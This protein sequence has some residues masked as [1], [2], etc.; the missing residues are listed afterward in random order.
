MNNLAS[1]GGR[2]TNRSGGYCT[3]CL[4]WVIGSSLITAALMIGLYLLANQ[5]VNPV[6][7]LNGVTTTPNSTLSF[8]AAAL[9]VDPPNITGT[10]VRTVPVM[11]VD[12]HVLFVQVGSD[13]NSA[14]E[15][16]VTNETL[17]YK[18]VTGSNLDAAQPALV[19]GSVSEAG[20]SHQVT[21]WGDQQGGRIMAKVI[22]YS[23]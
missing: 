1:A 14:I 11:K 4:G 19:T 9:P 10:V 21:V 12:G 13:Q 20:N 7:I 3:K 17:I 5:H 18:D 2:T 22:V 8:S 23:P 6:V 16:V 15:V